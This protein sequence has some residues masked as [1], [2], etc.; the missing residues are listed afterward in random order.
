MNQLQ[1]IINAAQSSNS[2]LKKTKTKMKTG[3]LSKGATAFFAASSSL[4][5]PSVVSAAEAAVVAAA[6]ASPD[7]LKSTRRQS[8]NSY[9]SNRALMRDDE[10]PS[11]EEPDVASIINGTP[12]GGPLPYQVGLTDGPNRSM[13]CGGSLIA[14][15]VVLTAAHCIINDDY[16]PKDP[17]RNKVLING[18]DLLTGAI[19]EDSGYIAANAASIHP[20]YNSATFENDIALWFLPIP[21]AEDDNF[22]F[23]TLNEDP[24]VPADGEELFVSGWGRTVEGDPSSVSPVLL[25]TIVDYVTNEQCQSDYDKSENP[26]NTITDD[27][28]CAAMGGTDTCQADSGGPLMIANG[29]GPAMDPPIQVGIVSWGEGCADPDYPG[30][31]TRVSSYID[32][33]HS[34]ATACQEVGE[35]CPSSSKSGKG[36]SKAYKNGSP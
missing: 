27:M 34:T 14:P 26:P 16:T 23:A 19:P 32:W 7:D 15:R 1:H 8:S 5:L 22:K 11:E 28:M 17:P 25:G 31:Y 9:A 10:H 2:R 12:T 24:T 35:L 21:I 33:I 6:A 13:G 29:D 30:V 4:S 3:L 20:G 18:Y 36:K